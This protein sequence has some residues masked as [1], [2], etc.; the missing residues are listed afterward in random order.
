MG[1]LSWAF[2]RFGNATADPTI[3]ALDGASARSFMDMIRSVMA[4]SRAF[5]DDQG[6]AIVTTGTA[7]AYVAATASGVTT[8]RPGL[9]L[10]VKID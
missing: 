9:S 7:N 5:A 6:G 10:L 2:D 1:V 4:G 8:L 3:P